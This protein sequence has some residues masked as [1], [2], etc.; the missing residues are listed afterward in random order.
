LE[1]TNKEKEFTELKSKLVSTE[2]E[3]THSK[4]NLVNYIHSFNKLEEK[5]KSRIADSKARFDTNDEVLRL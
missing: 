2:A 5:V 1:A 3:L 4:Q